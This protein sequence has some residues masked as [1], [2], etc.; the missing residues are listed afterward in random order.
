MKNRFVF[1][2]R[3]LLWLVA[4]QLLNL[5]LCG[6]V[7]QDAASYNSSIDP[8]ESLVE[9]F[10]EMHFG[11]LA[12]FDYPHTMDTHKGPAKTIHWHVANLYYAITA[13]H[14]PGF[15]PDLQLDQALL[16][17]RIADRSLDRPPR[18]A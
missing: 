16:Y 13:E 7:Y 5:S 12:A 1:C 18:V 2:R 17:S 8:T 9:W 10:A 15:S 3:L 6:D 11:Q 4:A 14:Y